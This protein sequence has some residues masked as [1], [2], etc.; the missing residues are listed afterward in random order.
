[1]HFEDMIEKYGKL[2]YTCVGVSMRPML[3]QKRDILIIEKKPPERFKRG[4][5]V[6]YKRGSQYVLHRVIKVRPDDYIILG[7][8]CTDYEY[9]ADDKIIGILTSFVRD[10]K[11]YRVNGLGC[12]I[13]AFIWMNTS[14]VRILLKKAVYYVRKLC[15]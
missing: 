14:S 7:D 1:M 12:R 2:V 10:G 13:Y 5:I 15:K 6:L 8:N 11:E 9:V 4:D 3:C